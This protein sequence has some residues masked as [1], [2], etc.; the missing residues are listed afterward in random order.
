ML[1]ALGVAL[2]LTA[3]GDDDK[4]AKAG[5][6]LPQPTG[7]SG[8]ME[9][10]SKAERLKAED[11]KPVKDAVDKEIARFD[12]EVRGAFEEERFAKLDLLARDLRDSNALFPDGSWKIERFYDALN[13]RAEN[14]EEEFI[15]D[16]NRFVK[17]IDT[18]P[19][20][21]TARIGLGLCFIRYAWLGR[22]YETKDTVTPRE[23]ALF[24]ERLGMAHDVLMAADM[25]PDPDPVWYD[26]M[27]Q[28]AIGQRWSAEKFDALVTKGLAIAPTYWPLT[29]TR[30]FSL[31]PIWLGKEGD[32][33]AYAEKESRRPD[34]LGD[35]GY[36]RIV[37]RMMFRY[38]DVFRDGKAS[39]PKT[40]KGLEILRKKYPEAMNFVNFTARMA[41]VGR[42]RELAQKM[43]AQMG[44]GYSAY[45]WRRP[46]NLT[47]LRNWAETGQW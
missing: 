21:K 27:A 33:Q 12:I 5:S 3:C 44:D 9:N 41:C 13:S 16:W 18:T 38:A 26:A 32:W 8:P 17:W 28:I 45:V 42:D 43:F 29:V 14:T 20:S 10:I 24:L 1:S 47:H 35:E 39:W 23:Q 19:D 4:A 36:A 31:L 7:K 2:C 25:L 40:R 30:A 46:E 34:G 22:G 15:A 11:L 37:C 6:P